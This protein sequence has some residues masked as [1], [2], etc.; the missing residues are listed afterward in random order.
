MPVQQFGL[1]SGRVGAC[2]TRRGRE[3]GRDQPSAII[4]NRERRVRL[5]LRAASE[6]RA[7]E[8]RGRL[9]R[10]SQA[11]GACAVA[12]DDLALAVLWALEL[13]RACAGRGVG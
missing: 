7:R 8:L 5:C 6:G 9:T 11:G 2:G 3:G 10:V 12:A 13:V 4:Q 1:F